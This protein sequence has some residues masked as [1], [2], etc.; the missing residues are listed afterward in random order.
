MV[1]ELK[2]QEF[3]SNK[4][5]CRKIWFEIHGNSW[6]WNW[7]VQ[8]LNSLSRIDLMPD[9]KL[10]EYDWISKINY[11]PFFIFC[12]TLFKIHPHTYIFFR[13]YTHTF[14]KTF[15]ANTNQKIVT[16]LLTYIKL[17]YFFFL[18]PDFYKIC[19]YKIH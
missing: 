7:N 15:I 18:H 2:T 12:E 19:T 11:R 3:E 1:S 16:T 4:V 17:T 9:N 13:K 8:N 10:H 14:F 6:H 5:T